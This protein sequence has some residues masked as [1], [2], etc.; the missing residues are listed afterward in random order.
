MSKPVVI[1]GAGPGGCAAAI[2]LAK[3]G[4]EVT[5]LEA[6]TLPRHRPGESL[7]PGVEPILKS[8]GVSEDV[9]AADF[10]R[11]PGC[12]NAWSG[13]AR[14]E[15]FGSDSRG[16]WF[17]YQASRT[18]FDSILLNEAKLCG[19]EVRQQCRVRKINPSNEAESLIVE[20]NSGQWKADWV[21]DGT[22]AH[23][24]VARN[25]GISTT[26]HSGP[27]T[28]YYGYVDA[29]GL[30]TNFEIPLLQ[31]DD[32]KWTWIAHITPT[33]CAWV[34]VHFSPRAS[35]ECP[36][37]LK[38]CPV[39]RATRR[40][41][42]TWRIRDQLAGPGWMLLGDAAAVLDP[43]SSHGV[44]RSLMSGMQAAHLLK[45]AKDAPMEGHMIADHYDQWLRTWFLNDV[46]RL[47]SFY[48]H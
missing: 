29:S 7:H 25:L 43:A 22:G 28:A 18:K 35:K 31:R 37:E 32:S 45:C 10:H 15:G 42:V 47:K 6:E 19:A 14:Y 46:A 2:Q 12:F 4:F 26:R 34:T 16:Q 41:D 38:N 39:T 24:L 8:L 9:E 48:E 44:L 20:S 23:A 30:D 11:H 21:L 27:L 17:G 5:L 40:C 13:D 33:C 36:P 3:A 1:I